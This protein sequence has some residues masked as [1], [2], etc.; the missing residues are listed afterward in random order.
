MLRPTSRD[1]LGG[2]GLESEVG[3]LFVK[4]R[5]PVENRGGRPGRSSGLLVAGILY[6]DGSENLASLGPL[7]NISERRSGG[8]TGTITGFEAR[9]GSG[10]GRCREKASSLASRTAEAAGGGG[11][12]SEP[13]ERDGGSVIGRNGG[14]LNLSCLSLGTERGEGFSGLL[15]GVLNGETRSSKEALSEGGAAG[16]N[17][18][19]RNSN[20]PKFA[21]F[22]GIFGLSALFT[23]GGRDAD[24]PTG[25][26]PL[27]GEPL[28]SPVPPAPRLK[29]GVVGRCARGG[30]GPGTPSISATLRENCW[31]VRGELS[32]ECPL[33][34]ACGGERGESTVSVGAACPERRFNDIGLVCPLLPGDPLLLG[35]PGPRTRGLGDCALC[36]PGVDPHGERG[37]GRSRD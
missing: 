8:A 9:E 16:V 27:P 37:L 24:F 31:C 22:A 35:V 34:R 25:D 3:G 2:S 28:F 30:L 6:V 36:V 23:G 32:P 5:P 21:A 20:C 1:R 11:G 14:I 15:G 4:G 19:E 29:F 10:T 17:E 7:D 13:P 18:F 12:L 33:S 26:T